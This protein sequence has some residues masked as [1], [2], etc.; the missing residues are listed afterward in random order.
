MSPLVLGLP[1]VNAPGYLWV[2]LAVPVLLV[3][4]LVALRRSRMAGMRFPNTGLLAM[5]MRPQSRWKRHVAVVMSLL[6]LAAATMAWARPVGIEKVPRERATIVVAI[7]ASLSMSATDVSPNRLD[8]AKAQAKTFVNS[9]PTGFNVAVVTVSGHPSVVMPPSTDRPTVLRAIDAI[10]TT[11]GTALGDAIKESLQAITEAPK[12]ADGSAA[13][14]AVVLLSDGGNTDG[15]DPMVAANQ[16]AAAK[17]PV[18]TIAFGTP[19]GYVDVDGQRERVAPDTTLLA[20]IAQ[21]THGR[22]WGADS[23]SKLKTVYQDVRSSVGY[24][25][26]K[27]EVT[28]KWAFYALGFAVVAGLGVVS[29]A[30]RWP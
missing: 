12:G 29:M 9:L 18:Y 22:S 21:R 15:T 19:T 30:V 16:A 1:Q 27:K 11:D 10:S 25:D 23:T 20:N 6:A 14:A 26:V 7:D 17:V 8:A 4:Y 2:L 5:V 13:P 24:E 28:A 3:L